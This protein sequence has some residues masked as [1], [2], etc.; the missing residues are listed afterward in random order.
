MTKPNHKAKGWRG[1]PTRHALSSH[2]IS[3]TAKAKEKDESS[4]MGQGLAMIN[5]ALSLLSFGAGGRLR[6]DAYAR[7]NEY[8]EHSDYKT[9]WIA[10]LDRNED[11]EIV[12]SDPRF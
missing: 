5:T 11:G 7:I 10:D 2:G 6:P 4:S 1:D 8:N 3:T 9:E 12:L